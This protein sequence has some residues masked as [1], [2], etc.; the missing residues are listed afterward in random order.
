MPKLC[1]PINRLPVDVF[2]QIPRFFTKYKYNYSYFPMVGP[3]ITM[4]H[5]CRSW[6]NVLLSTPNLWTQIDFSMSTE[7]QQKSFLL[8]A[9]N[10]PLHIHHYLDDEDNI[11][12]F[13]SIARNNLFRLQ[14]L[15]ITSCLHQFE[16]LLRVFS[17]AAAPQLKHLE[18]ANDP[19]ITEMDIKL[20]VIFGGRMPN[21]TT[22]DLHGFR[23]NL[24]DFNLPSLTRFI[25]DTGAKILVQDLTS[26]FERC[27][28]LEFVQINLQ[29]MPKPP[30]A[31]P[32]RRVCVP[33]LQELRLDQTACTTGL[34]D[35][36][37]LP[38][39]TEMM[40]KGQFTSAALD[41]H[42]YHAARIHASSI[43]HIS[44]M[45]G[46][47]KAVAM[48]NSCIFSGPNGN[49]RFWCFGDRG[50]FNAEFFTSFSP[51]SVSQ[52]RELWVGRGT[53]SLYSAN[54]PWIPTTAGVRGAFEVLTKVED[55]T[56]VSCKTKPIFTTLQA[57]V[58]D[59]RLL[60]PGLK[61]LT[62]YVGIGDLDVSALIQCAKAR[63]GLLQSLGEVTI[64]WKKDPGVDV[65]QE[66]ESLRE[67]VGELTQRVGRTPKLNWRGNNCDS[68]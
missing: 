55:L 45:R 19:N 9:G 3:L 53:E 30:T 47:T 51:I 8:R 68:W 34:L 61:R 57:T 48:P 60:L 21:L 18:L 36:L 54:Q 43:D 10:Q 41:S 17:A 40:L 56:I 1:S 14:E 44:V 23:T 37:I 49:L 26:F 66:V 65:K 62:I 16:H 20:P 15:S 25:F 12:P 58:D 13:L 42:G 4:T 28:S 24:R 59:G 29:Y 64:V 52:I 2:L 67:F 33:A 63:K 31:P 39:C 46:I 27:P 6:R 22:L 7:F 5:V 38:K 35:H 11:Q 32:R 50:N